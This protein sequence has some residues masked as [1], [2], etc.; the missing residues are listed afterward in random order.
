MQRGV[1]DS[2]SSFMSAAVKSVTSLTFKKLFLSVGYSGKS[3]FVV[4]LL[5]LFTCKACKIKDAKM[6]RLRRG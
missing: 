5:K 6:T 4:V 1:F 2:V 3:L